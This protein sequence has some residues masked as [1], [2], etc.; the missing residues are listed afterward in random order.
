MQ[1][2]DNPQVAKTSAMLPG[3]NTPDRIDNQTPIAA[4]P[5]TRAATANDSDLHAK[6]MSVMFQFNR[7]VPG[8]LNDSF[9]IDGRLKSHLADGL[10]KSSLDGM[11]GPRNAAT[12]AYAAMTRAK[13]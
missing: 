9:K 10:V 2:S 12:L 6:G 11:R 3:A 5:E 8:A 7:V 13:A 4:H 1:V